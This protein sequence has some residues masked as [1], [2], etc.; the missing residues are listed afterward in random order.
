MIAERL[1]ISGRVQ[2]V[3]YR[4]W[5]LREAARLGLRGWVRNVGAAQVE[6]VLCGPADAV[7][8]A[9]ALCWTGPGPAHVVSVNREACAVPA[10]TGFEQR[11]SV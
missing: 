5:L 6:A 9:V 3:G 11:P 4:A 1:L 2:G 10:G 7:A 8:A